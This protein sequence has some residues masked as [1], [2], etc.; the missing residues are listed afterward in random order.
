MYWIPA[1]FILFEIVFINYLDT[2][3]RSANAMF[4]A[5]KYNDVDLVKYIK[6]EFKDVEKYSGILGVFLVF[7]FIYFAVG[8]FYPFWFLSVI[9]IFITSISII[10]SKIIKKSPEIEKIIK[11][12]NL[13]DFVSSDVKFNRLLKLNE[14]NTNDIKTKEW[15]IYLYSVLKMI[16][17]ISIIVLH[18]NYH[19][20]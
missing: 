13:R 15:H 2:M 18:Y 8:F 12:A 3:I 1:F 19:I 7:E 16:A 5:K 14:L 10:R 9:F 17:F 6:K 11:L 4:L 20:L